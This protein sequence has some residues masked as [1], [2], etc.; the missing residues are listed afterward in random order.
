MALSLRF[1][2]VQY[3]EDPFIAEGRNVAVLAFHGGRG[4][5]RAL[6]VD[7]YNLIPSHFRSL[8][9]KADDSVWVYREWVEWF[10]SLSNIRDAEQFDEAAARLASN[11]FGLV[12]ASEGIVELADRFGDA[13]DAMDYLFRRLV[14]VP[15]ISPALAFDDR[16]EEVLRQAEIYY[17]GNFL[18]EPVEVE[19][20]SEDDR[21]VVTL[22]FS[23]LLTGGRPIGFNTLVLQGTAKKSL[24]RQ[25]ERIATTFKNTA[26]TGFLPPDRCI[27]LCDRMEDKHREMLAQFSGIAEVMDVFDKSTPSKISGL[28]WH[29]P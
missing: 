22:E 25:A 8:S 1:H 19:M 13:S 4:H 16:L 24:S 11:N 27:L 10:R 3:V 26:R 5:C 20:A 7:G 15:R 9:P 6:G 17:G 14:R 23:H 29:H 18:D 2:V 12:A 28:V 21:E